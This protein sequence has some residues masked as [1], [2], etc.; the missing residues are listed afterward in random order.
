MGTPAS[1]WRAFSVAPIQLYDV[2][3]QFVREIGRVGSG[4]QE[5]MS[6]PTLAMKGDTIVALDGIQARVMLFTLD[7]QFIRAFPVGVRGAP[8]PVGV[9]PR[10]YVRVQQHFG[11]RSEDTVSRVQW[12]YY[13]TRG[14]LVDSLRRPPLPAPKRWNV[15]D[16]SRSMSF[17]IPLTPVITDVFLPDGTLM[18]GVADRFQFVVTRTG[19]DTVR[20]FGRSD[21]PPLPVPSGFID[22]TITDMTRA[23]PMLQQVI[24]RSDFPAN[25]P[26]W[27][28]ATVDNKG[29]IW[30][31]LGLLSRTFAQIGIYAPD[32]RYLGMVPL[33]WEKVDQMSFGA[34]R[35]A[36]V[37]YDKE[38][39]AV[40]RIYK[41]DRRGM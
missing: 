19:R 37:S 40:L 25:F 39:R 1:D 27:N 38:R 23:Q 32:G 31:S 22:T 8:I 14:A 15:L 3:G 21:R 28:S 18:Y 29:Y 6:T 10:G 35:M 33:W 9:D 7:G 26:L 4:P 5:F 16:G 24:K 13:T 36:Y 41:I 11:L 2:Q 12:L 30:I 17:E 20:I 34:D